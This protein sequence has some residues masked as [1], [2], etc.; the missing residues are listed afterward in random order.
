MNPDSVDTRIRPTVLGTCCIPWRSD[1][2]FDEPL[3]RA[4]VEHLHQA[5]MQNLYVF[6][7]AGEGHA[8]SDIQFR[9]IVT[10]FVDQMQQLAAVPMVASSIFRYRRYATE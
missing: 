3:F 10:A 8:V 4:T 1:G 2:R 6:G 7:T 5:G 9:E